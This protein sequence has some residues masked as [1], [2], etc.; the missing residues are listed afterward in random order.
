M[1]GSWN[2]PLRQRMATAFLGPVFL[3]FGLSFQVAVAGMAGDTLLGDVIRKNTDARG[4]A[5]ALEAVRAIEIELTITEP[6]FEVDALYRATREGKMRIDIFADGERVFTEGFDGSDG[7]QLH[8]GATEATDMSAE[9]QAAVKHGIVTN[10]HGLHEFPGLGHRLLLK[11]RETVGGT[12]YLVVDVIFDDG[13]V[14]RN[15]L[16]PQTFLVARTRQDAALHPDVDPEMR[17][18]ETREFDYRE[19]DGIL[20]AFRTVKT[21]LDNNQQVQS[22]LARKITI[23]PDLDAAIFDR[24]S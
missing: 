15:Y 16:D 18:F 11:G 2:S 21:D 17:R 7:W 6:T 9:G 14:S 24:P 13:F 19:I 3:W 10:L 12:N 20:L 8:G 22:T 1:I 5:A 4:G 23:N